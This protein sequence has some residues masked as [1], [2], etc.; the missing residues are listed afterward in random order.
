MPEKQQRAL[1]WLCMAGCVE[2]SIWRPGADQVAL[3]SGPLALNHCDDT[4][5]R[6]C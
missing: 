3:T 2:D 6:A 4:T 1:P 5:L